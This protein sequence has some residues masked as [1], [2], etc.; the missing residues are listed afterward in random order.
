MTED[1][2]APGFPGY[3]VPPVSVATPCDALRRAMDRL[4][5]WHGRFILPIHD[6]DLDLLTVWI[7]HTHYLEPCMIRTTPRLLVDSPLP[8]SGKTTVLEHGNKFGYRGLQAATITSDALLAR[9]LENGL[10]TILIDEA[11]KS[12]R[13]DRPVT[14]DLLAMVNSGYKRGGTRPVLVPTKSGSYEVKE[15]P[16]FAPVA[17]AGIS[18]D[19]P[20]DT[21]SR[22]IRMLIL[23]DRDGVVEPSDWEFIDEEAD[24]LLREIESAVAESMQAVRE[25]NRP[26]LPEGIR[27]RMAEKWRPLKRIADVAGGRWPDAVDSLAVRELRIMTEDQE[28]EIHPEDRGL[29]LIRH[30]VIRWPRSAGDGSREAFWETKHV[31]RDLKD[32]YPDDWGPSLYYPK[33]L[34][35]Q[36]IGR[37]LGIKWGVRASR[38]ESLE[39]RPRGYLWESLRH[40]ATRVGALDLDDLVDPGSPDPKPGDPLE[41]PGRPGDRGNRGEPESGGPDPDPTEPANRPSPEETLLEQLGS[42]S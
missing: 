25:H 10:R 26:E 16:S 24:D 30:M 8:A 32:T 11:E 23:P 35:A 38:A 9:C 13:P 29:V 18:P 15:M 17:M 19:L 42:P 7:L 28:Q 3:P 20:G 12:L 6:E 36:R 2:D 39:H 33:G 5:T 41:K 22:S 21:L 40:V 31:V 14:K 27:G 4:R 34:T 1:L 37:T